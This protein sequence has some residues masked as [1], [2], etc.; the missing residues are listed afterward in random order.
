MGVEGAATFIITLP[1]SVKGR[2][3]EAHLGDHPTAIAALSE[4]LAEG[5]DPGQLMVIERI[6]VRHPSPT[7][8]HPSPTYLLHSRHH[9]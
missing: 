1:G 2:L 3:D 7:S 8:H 5:T 6:Q 9:D 4:V